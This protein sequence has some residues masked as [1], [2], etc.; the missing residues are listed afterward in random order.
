MHAIS[1][2]GDD[3]NEP[4]LPGRDVSET[5]YDEPFG[6]WGFPL[7]TPTPRSLLWLIQTGSLD[8]RLG[9]FLSLAVEFRRSIVVIAEQQGAGKTTLLTTLLDFMP[10][11][12]QPIYIRGLYERFTFLD[13]IPPERAYLLCNEISAHLPTYLWGQGVRRVF[14]A[15]GEGYPLLTTMHAGST[16]AALELLERYPLEIPSS[17]VAGID[18][19]VALDVG[20]VNSNLVHRVMSTDLVEADGNGYRIM[21]VAGRTLLRSPMEHR[22]GRLVA[23]VA[24]WAGCSDNVAGRILSHRER[25]LESLIDQGLTAPEDLRRHLGHQ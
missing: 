19:V 21:Q 12:A 22:L 5:R 14:Q 18:L 10:P 15:V 24:S 1:G 9:A 4:S 3:Q 11:D 25:F 23:A 13:T 7:A 6:W 17:E 8:A 20:Y 2:N 16:T